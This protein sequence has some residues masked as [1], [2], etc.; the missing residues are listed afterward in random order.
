MIAYTPRR[1]F[2]A[3]F[4]LLLIGVAM[5]TATACTASSDARTADAPAPTTIGPENMT[6]VAEDTIESGPLLSG[7]LGAERQATVRAEIGGTVLETNAEEGERVARGQVLARLD[8]TSIRDAFLGARSGLTTA[9]MNARTATRE[10]E[11][12]ER[13]AEAGAIAERDLEQAR[14]GATA[15]ASML[16]DAK[17]RFVAAEKALSDTRVRAPFAGIVAR[18]Q[19]SAGETVAPGGAMFDVIDPSTMRLEASVPATELAALRIGAPVS[20]TVSGYP[21][22]AFTGRITRISPVAD[23]TT[24][25]V[26]IFASIPNAGQALVGGLFAE[27]RV[28]SELRVSA[29]AP[30]A[31]LDQRGVTPMA[32]RVRNGEVDRVE[33]ELGIRDAATE[34]YEIISGVQVGDTLLLGPAQGLSPGT[35]VV[36]GR[37]RD[38]ASAQR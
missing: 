37:T 11:R 33:V 7:S 34:H 6:V 31:A 13:L 26:R 22:R 12:M 16:A 3:L 38:S 25:Q 4:S 32:V 18:R 35:R 1:P 28:A 15:A 20:F 9:E 14:N 24:R 29:I 5:G 27:G 23:A 10:L 17:A 2:R 21:G 19:V 8:E 36:F 30:A